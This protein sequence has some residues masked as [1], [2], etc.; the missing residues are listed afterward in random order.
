MENSQVKIDFC[1]II[2]VHNSTY[3]QA[4]FR[5]SLDSKVGKVKY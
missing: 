3:P 5:C 1:K 4:G 2:A